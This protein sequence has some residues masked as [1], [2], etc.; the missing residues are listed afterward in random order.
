MELT[1]PTTLTFDG[2]AA[3]ILATTDE[4]GLVEMRDVPAGGM[5]PLHVH[6][7]HDEGFYV[8]D[9]EVTLY[10]PGEETTLGAGDFLLAPRG[11]PHTYRVADDAPASWLVTSTPGGFERFVARAAALGEAPDPAALTAIAAEHDI[12]ILGPPGALPNA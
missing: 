9:G 7:T 1:H 4:L 2:A 11:V 8:L 12:E 3:R 5:P 6:H 10:T